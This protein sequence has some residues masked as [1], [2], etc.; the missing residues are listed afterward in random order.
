LEIGLLCARTPL[1]THIGEELEMSWRGA[2]KEME[3]WRASGE[4]LGTSWR[5]TG[6]E[7]E[8]GWRGAGE[9]LRRS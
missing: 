8:R 2:G 1:C 4:E 3:T 7:L 6:D 9:E 5:G